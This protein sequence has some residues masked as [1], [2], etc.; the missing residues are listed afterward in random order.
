MSCKTIGCFETLSTLFERPRSRT[1]IPELDGLRF[2]ALIAVMLWHASIR[3]TRYSESNGMTSGLYWFFPHG[4]VGVLLFFF[5]SGYVVSQP[6]IHRP[7][8]QWGVPSFYLSR[9]IRIY[10]PYLVALTVCYLVLQVIGHVPK[11]ASSYN[12][13]NIS[14]TSSYLASLFYAHGFVFNVPS[15]LNPP[16]W[17]LEIEIAFYVFAPLILHAYMKIAS[18]THRL[19]CLGGVIG[20]LVAFNAVAASHS[21]IEDSYRWAPLI[22]GY[23]FLFGILVADVFGEK[24]SRPRPKNF[25]CDIVFA[26][27]LSG[28]LGVGLKMTQVDA[29]FPGGWWTLATEF[30]ILAFLALTFVGAFYGSL[31]SA[32]LSLP[33]IRWIGTMCYSIYLT[34]IV[35]MQATSELIAKALQ[36]TSPWAIWSVWICVLVP[37]S[38][39]CGLIFYVFVERPFALAAQ[40]RPAVR[41][42]TLA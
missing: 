7:R 15:R 31:S 20:G 18:K 35:V 30:C 9:A 2:I 5:I 12:S 26:I 21:E 3:A 37:V 19:I 17:S 10:P 22:H 16:I 28:L 14:L 13:S 32:F 33:W 29:D 36:L 40:R 38:L 24:I 11:G 42:R 34:H 39:V 6:F 8:A 23:L 25:Y 1:Y 27:G 41:V 4:E